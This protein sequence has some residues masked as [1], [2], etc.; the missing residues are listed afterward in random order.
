VLV[1]ALCRALKEAAVIKKAEEA[2]AS[3]VRMAGMD[4]KDAFEE[5]KRLAAQVGGRGWGG[6]TGLVP[7]VGV[8]VGADLQV[9]WSAGV[10]ARPV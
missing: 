10:H 4:G 7:C 8:G 1:L 2:E 6:F 5:L 3:L 9:C